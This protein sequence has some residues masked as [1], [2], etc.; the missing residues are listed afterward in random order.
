VP[1]YNGSSPEPLPGKRGAAFALTQGASDSN[2]PK[3]L[4]LK[5]YWFYSWSPSVPDAVRQATAGIEFLPMVWG[6]YSMGDHD[7]TL[8][9]LATDARIKRLLGFNEPDKS[10]QANLNVSDAVTYWERI[11]SIMPQNVSLVSPACSDPDGEWMQEFMSNTARSAL[12]RQQ[13]RCGVG[14]SASQT[15]DYV[16]VHWYGSPDVETFQSAMQMYYSLYNRTLMI[17]EFAVADWMAETV[18]DNRYSREG[19]L[20]FMKAALPW[21]EAQ[22][23][24]AAYSWFPYEITDPVGTSSSLFDRNGNLTRLG[25]YYKSVTNENPAGNQSISVWKI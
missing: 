1:D 4:A 5:P 14:N 18:Q 23:W 6:A 13:G 3:L 8:A 24:I 12:S 15:I 11:E 22:S 2:L 25:S 21:L 9:E 19:V 16:A 17:T 7:S 10:S 20:E